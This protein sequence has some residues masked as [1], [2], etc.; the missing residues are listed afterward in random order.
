MQEDATNLHHSVKCAHV[1]PIATIFFR[2]SHRNKDGQTLTNKEQKAIVEDIF[3][4]MVSYL[5]RVTQEK[6]EN[7]KKKEK[8]ST[9]LRYYDSLADSSMIKNIK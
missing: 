2:F 8:S 3:S 1:K 4:K 6:Q 9:Y 7:T 5:D